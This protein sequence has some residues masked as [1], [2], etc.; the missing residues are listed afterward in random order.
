[1]LTR[2][3]RRG[4]VWVWTAAGI[5]AVA[6]VYLGIHYPFD[7]LAGVVTGLACAWVA[8]RVPRFTAAR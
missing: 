7:A 1:V 4:R 8:L 5:V 2:V 6:R 3:W